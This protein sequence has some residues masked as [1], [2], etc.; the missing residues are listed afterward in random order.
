MTE[1]NPL[2]TGAKAIAKSV[3][4]KERQVYSLYDNGEAPIQNKRGVGYV[5]DP[6]ELR[7]W[8]LGKHTQNRAPEEKR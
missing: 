3:G 4:I 1:I 8:L 6:I 2:T 5:A 7:A